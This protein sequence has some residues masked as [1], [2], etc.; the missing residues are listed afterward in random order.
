[1]RKRWGRLEVELEPD[2]LERY[3]CVYVDVFSMATSLRGA[4]SCSEALRNSLA[5]RYAEMYRRWLVECALSEDK[6]AEENAVK[7]ACR[8]GC[9]VLTRDLDAVRK[10][11]ELTA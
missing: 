11:Q 1:M 7:L 10:A 6:P 2:V 4:G 9:A 5:G 8:G 3:G